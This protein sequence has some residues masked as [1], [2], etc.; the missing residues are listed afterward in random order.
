MNLP[1]LSI[2]MFSPVVGA[3]IIMALPED[4]HTDI[5][6][7]AAVASFISCLGSIYAFFAYDHT[8]GGIQ[9]EE[10]VRWI[11]GLGVSY[12]VGVDGISL[13]L[14]LLTGVIIFSGVLVS[15]VRDHRPREFFAMLLLLVTG[16][17]GTFVALDLFLLFV[18]YELAVLP[19]Y[20]LIG[21]WGTTRKEYAA[22]KLT[23]YLLVGSSIALAGVLVASVASG[24]ST[25]DL[26]ELAKANFSPALQA[27]IFLPI[28]IGFDVLG[29]L[30]PLHTWSPDGHVAAPTAVSMLHAGVLM[31]MGAYAALRVGVF[32]FPD[33]ARQWLPWI[34]IL[35][36]VNVVYGATVAFAQRDIKYVIG[37]SSVSHM[38]YVTMGVATLSQIGLA[39]A[40]MQMFSHGIMTGIFFAA[41]G[42]VYHRT[43]TRQIP[44]LGGLVRKLPFVAVAFIIAGLSSMGMPGFS[45]FVA[46]F[47][48]LMGVWHTYPI[49]AA[50]S[51]I[52]V[53]VTA[54]YIL[55]FTY[56]IFFGPLKEEFQD[57]PPT[58]TLE[59]V[60]LMFMCAFIVGFGVFPQPI[61]AVIHTG[62][63]EL[64]A[65]IR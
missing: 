64:L 61:L 5:K 12:H 51:L 39:G 38:G 2:I 43:H 15:W 29:G 4:R 49:I 53:V 20:L 18:C 63:S 50:I 57:I 30:W 32:L 36:A 44:E 24:L 28:F 23:L 41:V 1:I 8:L 46:E 55:R 21:I 60:A 62:V 14:V 25:F 54:A 34:I 65:A 52:G 16:V 19:M 35:T 22:M 7:T 56:M 27:A 13:P 48:V 10:Q 58:S 47:Q 40:T 17:F 59:K 37:Y 42:L 6:A 9:F 45:G 33:G 11:P 3:L 26:L 31:K